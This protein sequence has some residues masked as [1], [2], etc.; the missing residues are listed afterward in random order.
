[1]SVDTPGRGPKRKEAAERE[2]HLGGGRKEKRELNRKHTW[3]GGGK[4]RGNCTKNKRMPKIKGRLIRPTHGTGA[5][6]KRLRLG[7]CR[8][9]KA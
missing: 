8:K 7:M 4:K 5:K 9:E 1:M 2:T 3:V 6:M